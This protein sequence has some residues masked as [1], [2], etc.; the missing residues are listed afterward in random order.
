MT[1]RVKYF[2]L[3]AFPL[4]LLV[5]WTLLVVKPKPRTWIQQ[6]RMPSSTNVLQLWRQTDFIP[7]ERSSNFTTRLREIPF[8]HSSAPGPTDDQR[9]TAVEAAQ[10][11]LLAFGYKDIEA[12]RRFRLPVR[13]YTLDDGMMRYRYSRLKEVFPDA[14]ELRELRTEAIID[15]WFQS[16]FVP[17]DSKGTFLH[18]QT[19]R[20]IITGFSPDQSAFFYERRSNMPPPL[21]LFVTQTNNNGYFEQRPFVT[22]SPNPETL[23]AR[24]QALDILTMRLHIATQHDP[25]MPIYFRLYWD[26]ERTKWLPMEHAIPYAL[27]REHNYAF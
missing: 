6:G 3:L 16:M 2:V 20:Q 25:P 22:F 7:I 21:N 10:D 1:G 12:Y 15:L 17:L 5:F 19:L 23:L 24:Y 27:Q 4:F 11:F 18:K 14:E 8:I 26:D 13:T 9:Q